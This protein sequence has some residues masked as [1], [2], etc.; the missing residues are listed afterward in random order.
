MVASDEMEDSVEIGGRFVAR[1]VVKVAVQ[2][3]F[4]GLAELKVGRLP[5]IHVEKIGPSRARNGVDKV[6]PR[7]MDSSRSPAIG[8]IRPPRIR[9]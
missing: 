7:V 9:E 2:A 4:L 5:H 8:S 3:Q 6:F 1:G